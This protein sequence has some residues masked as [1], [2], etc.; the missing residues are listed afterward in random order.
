MP[1]RLA[2]VLEEWHLCVLSDHNDIP[3]NKATS[4]EVTKG[5][6]YPVSVKPAGAT[7]QQNTAAPLPLTECVQ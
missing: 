3:E 6:S 2:K 7:Y 5:Y 4:E 1:G